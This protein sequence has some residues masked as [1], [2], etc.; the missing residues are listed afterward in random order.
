V[1]YSEVEEITGTLDCSGADTK[2]SFPK[3][4]TVGGYLDCRGADT[5]CSFPKLSTV[6]GSLYCRGADTKCSF[7]KL[8]TV[9]GSLDCS[10]ADTKCSFPKLKKREC[11]DAVARFR[12]ACAFRRKGFLF[13]DGILSEIVNTRDLR[14]GV[15]VHSIRVVGKTKVTYCIESDGTY[16]HGDT[17]KEARES[18][19]YKVSQRDKSA[20]QGWT[21]DRKITGKEAIASY[22]VITGACEAGVRAFVQGQGGL[23]SRYT[24][25][26][27]IKLTRGQYG[28]KEYEAFFAHADKE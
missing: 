18:L 21:M 6:G 16:S 3:L 24:V 12:V 2:C 17:I 19:L 23:K 7:P 4:S 27:V 15:K 10:G 5:K 25:K 9:G 20:Y 14:G 11:G 28:N 1:D 8:S 26:E 22:R 13:A